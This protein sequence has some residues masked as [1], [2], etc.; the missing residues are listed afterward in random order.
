MPRDLTEGCL[1]ANW[2]HLLRRG[3]MSGMPSKEVKDSLIAAAWHSYL[4]GKDA[5]KHTV[6]GTVMVLDSVYSP[7]L[8]N[9]RDILVY[10]PRTYQSSTQRYP[11]LY[12]HDGQNLFDAATSYA[13]EWHVDE[14]LE[15][16]SDE[17]IEAIV[18]GVPNMGVERI[19]ELSPF[20]KANEG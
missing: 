13:G 19:H 3:T 2:Q 18:V 17:G 14:T 5:A 16:L 7:Q 20:Q 11:V 10:L 6:S 12:M 8:D 15:A 4:D 9:H 1:I